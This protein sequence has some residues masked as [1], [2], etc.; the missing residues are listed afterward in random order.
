MSTILGPLALI[1]LPPQVAITATAAR[2][3]VVVA[4]FAFALASG[5]T[6][7][8]SAAVAPLPTDSTSST[9]R[10]IALAL[11]E[12]ASATEAAGKKI[13]EARRLSGLTWEE[14]ARA[15]GV[16]RR[17]LHLWANGRPIGAANEERLGR[18]LAAVR[19]VDRRTART[20]RD[21]IMTPIGMDGRLSLD[22]LNEGRFADFVAIVGRGAGRADG[23]S[24]PLSAATH[25]ARTPPPPVVLLGALQDGV[26][27]APRPL[28]PGKAVRRPARRS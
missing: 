19:A 28:V 8:S 25:G 6:T 22:L 2:Q 26:E 20:T 3:A 24:V 23:P 14:L 1:R 13:A 12:A 9:L 21:A 16:T 18:L 10:A 4:G 17:T 7:T 5:P 11:A 27:T 15:M